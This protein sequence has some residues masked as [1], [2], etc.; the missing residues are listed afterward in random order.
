MASYEGLT[1]LPKF[2]HMASAAT[3]PRSRVLDLPGDV[4][5]KGVTKFNHFYIDPSTLV[6]NHYL[7]KVRR[8]V[9]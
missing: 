8:V 7:T 1:T 3:E 5:V 2:L 4:H 6:L 9:A